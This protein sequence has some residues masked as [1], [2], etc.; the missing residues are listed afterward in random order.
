[1]LRGFIRTPTP[2]HL[3]PEPRP[4]RQYK[5]P[6]YRATFG[7]P[8]DNGEVSAH[9]VPLGPVDR[10]FGSCGAQ[11]TSIHLVASSQIS[12]GV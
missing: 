2:I 5:S 8:L 7:L 4:A 9:V 3:T 6:L 10:L 12:N 11:F 1:M